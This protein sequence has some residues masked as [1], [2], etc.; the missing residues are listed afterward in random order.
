M[1]QHSAVRGAFSWRVWAGLF[2]LAFVGAAGGLTV[3]LTFGNTQWCKWVYIWQAYVYPEHEGGLILPPTDSNYT[4]QW[5]C[6]HSNGR[7]W[8]SLSARNGKHHGWTR[9][10]DRNGR[11]VNQEYYENGVWELS[12]QPA[13]PPMSPE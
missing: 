3:L 5:E 9:E 7:K 12:K 6:W 10:W 8:F 4:G 2:L 13:C 11:L 1:L